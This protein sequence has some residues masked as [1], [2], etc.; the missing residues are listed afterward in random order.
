MTAKKSRQEIAKVIRGHGYRAT[1]Q[2]LAIYDALHESGSHPTAQ[3]IHQTVLERDPSVSLATVY[4]TLQLF[5]ELGLAGE[6]GFRD[7]THYDPEME[8]HVHLVCT[9]C[10]K[11]ED[12]H[13]DELERFMSQIEEETEFEITGR[14]F[15]MYGLCSDCKREKRD[16]SPPSLA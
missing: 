12:L 7:Q 3:D 6:M 8:Y 15:D 11:I 1:P 10:G 2:R 5:V 14:R 9:N 13:V 4:K 16:I